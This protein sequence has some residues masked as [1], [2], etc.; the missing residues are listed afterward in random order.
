M[1]LNQ[2]LKENSLSDQGYDMLTV[3]RLNRS[4]IWQASL[5]KFADLSK[6]E[7]IK[8]WTGYKLHSSLPKSD[9]DREIKFDKQEMNQQA[10]KSE[11]PKNWDWRYNGNLSEVRN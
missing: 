1:S 2:G 8:A 4:G 7:F 11:N 9:Q 6:R 5:G 10:K 3:S